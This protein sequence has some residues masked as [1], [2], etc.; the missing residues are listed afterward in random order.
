[1]IDLYL[2]LP[3]FIVGVVFIYKGSDILVDGTAKTAVRLGISTLIISVI[4]IG[5][6]TS[7]PEFAISVGAAVQNNSEISLGNIIGSCIANLLLVLGVAAII[8]PIKIKKGIIKREFPIM[9]GATIVLLVSSFLGLLDKYHLIGG[10]LFLLLFTSFVG[11][12][13]LSARKE[14]DKKKKI[15]TEKTSKNL[16][17]IVL[18]IIGVVAGAWLLIESAVIIAEF[19][20]ISPFIIAISIVAVG[21][22]IPELV[23]SSMAAYKNEHDI[24]IGNVLGSNVFNI[25]L[26]LGFASLFIPLRALG[27]LTHLW[28]LL[29]V[30]LVMFLILYTGHSI[31]RKEGVFMLSLY[32]VFIWY[33]FF[34]YSLF[35]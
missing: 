7:A 11:Y 17:F 9:L 26:I 22:S 18:G 16:F 32:S 10:I 25:F 8:R 24:A 31:S 2:A 4:L 21:T 35:F 14:R 19:L 5:F 34:G 29:A 12:Y 33:T 3:A 13:V 20:H 23:V 28:I 6:G 30:T 27:S 15:D 1:M